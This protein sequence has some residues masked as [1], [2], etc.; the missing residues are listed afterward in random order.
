MQKNSIEFI[1]LHHTFSVNQEDLLKYE[2]QTNSIF[3]LQLR[4]LYLTSEN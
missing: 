1:V 2:E 3:N 4:R